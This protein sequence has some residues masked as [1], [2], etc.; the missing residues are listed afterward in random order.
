MRFPGQYFDPETEA[1]YNVHRHYQPETARYLFQDPL[2]L[3]PAP[4][5]ASYVNNPHTWCDPYGLSPCN[6]YFDN[7]SEAF[8]AAR[9]RAGVPNSQ[10]PVKQWEVGDD[11]TQRHR[12]SNYV[13]DPNPGAHG[14][15]YQYETPQGTRVI[16][17][18]TS[19]P[20]APYP[21]FH[22]GQPKGG[23]HNVDM[24]GERY[25]QVGDKHHLYYTG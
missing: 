1:H 5:P 2:G 20:N 11:P 15:Y 25:Q 22:A 7:R 16:A 8:N 24:M 4:N 14:R 13:Y 17:E 6:Q 3:T 19:D 23:G 12:T 21:H 10:Q 18:H 9:E